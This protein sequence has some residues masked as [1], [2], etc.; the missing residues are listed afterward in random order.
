MSKELSIQKEVNPLAEK[1][2]ALVIKTPKDMVKATEMLSTVNKFGDRVETEKM[3]VM[4]PLLDAQKAERARWKPIEEKVE[5]VVGILRRKMTDFQ[6]AAKKAAD[7]EAAKIEARIGEGKGKLKIDT[8][9]SKIAEIDTPDQSVTADSG[10][11]KFRTEKK[12][13]VVNITQLPSEY[14]LPDLVKI[15][16]AMKEGK[17]ITGVRY[18]TEEVP[19][20][21]R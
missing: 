10:M 20:N 16:A 3:K 19:V 8:A 4:R 1:A 5:F 11:V 14:L 15:R 18:F 13:E 12:F 21:L 2:E 9:V 17:E 7:I 6:T